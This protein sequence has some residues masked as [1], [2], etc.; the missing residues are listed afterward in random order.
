MNIKDLIKQYVNS[1]YMMQL[2][3]ANNNIP[4]CSTVYYVN[5]ELLNL[6]WLSLPSRRHSKALTTNQFASIAIPIKF[7][8][9][10]KVIGIQA[11]GVA[12]ELV[13]SESYR[14]IILKYSEKFN[15][16]LEWVDDFCNDQTDHKLYKFTVSKFVLFDEENF[17]NDTRKELYIEK[18]EG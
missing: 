7:I 8:N 14:D 16:T 5:D 10:E 1:K 15:R 4:W 11:E 2:A 18:P 3:T 13:S 6:Y 12:L 9:G 17:P